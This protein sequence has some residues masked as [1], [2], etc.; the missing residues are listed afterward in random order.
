MVLDFVRGA[1]IGMFQVIPGGSGGTIALIV[2]VYTTL[3]DQAAHL[4]R[5]ALVLVRG[6]GQ[7]SRW[8]AAW[9]GFRS[10]RWDILAPL[11]V[12]AVV[13]V[14]AGAALVEPLLADHPVPTRALFLGL[15]LAGSAVPIAMVRD[16]PPGGWRGRDVAI[17]AVGLVAAF[18]LTGLPPA[19]VADPG[20]LLIIAAAALAVSALVV[21]GVS[22][23]FLLL[24]MGLYTTTLQ[25]VNERDLGYLGLFAVGAVIGLGTFVLL[26]QWLLG[27]HGRLTL[28]IITGVMLGALRALWPWQ[29]PE[30]DLLAPSGG[31]GLA[32]AMFLLG[33]GAVAALLVLEQRF[34][35]RL[36]DAPTDPGHGFDE[37]RPVGA[38]GA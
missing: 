35:H 23:S 25:A 10:A 14:L 4:V 2:G 18:V 11:G 22:G 28:V 29:S 1:L 3:I 9:A 34:R 8:A 37:H 13:A 30:R 20:P 26:V 12:G 38:D 21:P 15:A 31:V 16:T 32:I 27:R 24:S 33:I 36:M 6:G 7:G 19:E 17:A 5:S